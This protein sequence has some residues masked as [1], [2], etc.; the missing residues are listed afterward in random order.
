M[1]ASAPATEQRVLVVDDEADIVALVAYHLARAGYR[2]STA[3][4]GHDAREAA[5]REQPALIVLDLMLPGLSGYEVLEQ[6]RADASTRDIAV[7]ML[8]ARREEQDRIRGLSLG[9]DDYLTKPF[10]PQ[11]LVLRV[12]AILRRMRTPPAETTAAMTLGQLEIDTAAHVVRVAGEPVELTPTEYKLLL[13]LAERRGRVQARAHLL[14]SVW[15][16]APDIQTRTVDMHVQR[17]RAKLGV[18]G[19]MIETVRGFGYRL[20]VPQG[21]AS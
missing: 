14:E 19:E 16:A 5:R 9:A 18:A 4:T 20:R 13:L 3:S 1:S 8:T 10:S 2:V 7:L 11:E 17:L 21:R 12:G 6:L 15:E